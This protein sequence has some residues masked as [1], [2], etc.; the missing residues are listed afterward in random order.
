MDG[1]P[2]ISPTIFRRIPDCSDPLIYVFL[3]F[4]SPVLIPRS[5]ETIAGSAREK[6]EYTTYVCRVYLF[7]Q[8]CSGNLLPHYFDN[9]AARPREPDTTVH[10]IYAKRSGVH[11][12][13]GA[14]RAR[15]PLHYNET[16][17]N[18]CN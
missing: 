6:V 8:A 9:N 18:D 1:P 2:L 4:R 12:P 3:S 10:V 11:S 17:F 16:M 5:Q 7:Y 15:R 13:T 14:L